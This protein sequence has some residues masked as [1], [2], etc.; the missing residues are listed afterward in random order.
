MTNTS[1]LLP[2]GLVVAYSK[3]NRAIGRAGGLPWHHPEDLKHFK[4]VT[5]GHAIVHGRKSYESFGR[6]LP[7]RRNIIVTRQ[8]GYQAP[9]CEVVGDVASAIRLARESDECPWICGG[10]QIYR[11]ALPLVTICELTE[12]DESVADADTFFPEIDEKLFHETA[13]RH[14]GP[15]HFRRLERLP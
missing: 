12:I 13:S 5:M 6:P 3:D 11:E 1:Q 4:K 14:S 7:G 8:A 10:E 9:G 15:L 2:L